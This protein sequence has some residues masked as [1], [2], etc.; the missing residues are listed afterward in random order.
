MSILTIGILL[1]SRILLAQSTGTEQLTVPL[2]NPGKPYSLNVSLLNGSIHV[3]AHAGKDILIDVVPRSSR[4]DGDDDAGNGMKRISRANGYEVVA[5][6]NDN[7]VTVSNQS[8]QR[9]LNLNLK[10]PQDVKLKLHTVNNG[11]I[12]V[13]GIKGELEINN[14]NGEIKLTNISGSVVATTVNGPVTVI[15]NTITPG[16]PMAFSTLN[17]NVDVTFPGGTKSNLKMKSDRGEVY[18]D[19][20]V[21]VDKSQQKVTRTNESGMHKITVDDWVYGKINGGGSEVLMKNMNGN[22][23]IRKAK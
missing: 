5:K 16:T 7:V 21:E 17:G 3:S 12:E 1:S 18:S 23:Y 13:D 6:E 19:F 14:V 11:T 2:T 15:F 10:I 22:I 8:S 20:D 4:D 9:T